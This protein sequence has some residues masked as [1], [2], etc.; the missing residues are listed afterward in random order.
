MTPAP[1]TPR[2]R[3]LI[4][5]DQPDVRDALSF[6]LE[7]EGM[8]AETAETSDQALDLAQCHSFDV[9]LSDI[10]HPGQDGLALLPVLKQRHPTVPVIIISA[11]LD[12]NEN[13]AQAVALGAFAC[14]HKPFKAEDVM[15]PVRAALE[16]R[17]Q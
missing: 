11:C 12:L 7:R 14:V 6:I 15:T 16:K 13:S 4:L 10:A 3:I 9:I 8:Q 1:N 5:D 17:R 2:P